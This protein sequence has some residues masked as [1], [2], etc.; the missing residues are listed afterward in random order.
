MK[1]IRRHDLFVVAPEAWHRLLAGRPDLDGVPHVATWAR[2]GRPV[3]VRRRFPGEGDHL[4][5]GLPLPPADGKRRIGLA[6]PWTDA[7][8]SPPVTLAAA[9]PAAPPAWHPT[10]DAVLA[11]AAEYGVVPQ[12]FGG[13]LWQR[14]TGLAYLS[15]TSDLDLLWPVPVTRR[16]L[17]GLATIDANAPMRLDG[18]VVL[19][20]GA[21]VNW[22]EL[23]DTPPG[24]SVLAKGLDRVAL[25]PAG[26]DR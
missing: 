19:P 22:R 25:V 14:L 3:I 17:D 11:L 24:G 16:L 1:A 7:T 8:P 23:R 21:G 9:R 15:T 5:A 2:D 6:V 18:E 10:V 26:L 4:P 13:L 12:V 20:D